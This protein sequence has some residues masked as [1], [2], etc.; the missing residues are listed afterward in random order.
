[1]TPS[2]TLSPV[3]FARNLGVLSD[4]NLSLS[5]RISSVIKSRLFHVRDIRRLEP[6]LDQHALLATALIYSKLDYCS[7]LFLNHPANQ[8]DRHKLVLNS[9]ARVVENTPKCHHIT[10]IL[11]S[12]HWLKIIERIHYKV[13][14][15]T[16][17]CLLS[18]KPAYLRNLLTVQSTSTIC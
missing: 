5:D 1:M 2:V 10:P 17:K 18:D 15:I 16:Y 3:S 14:Y 6:I 12:L 7:S 8:L 4:S 11:K 13:L 9:A